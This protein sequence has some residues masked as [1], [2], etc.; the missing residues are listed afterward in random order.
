MAKKNKRNI[1]GILLLDKP[2]GIG[3]N[4][5]LQ[6][7]K[8]SLQAKKAGHTGSLDPLASGLLP[9][10]FGEATKISQYLLESNKTYQVTAKLGIKTDSADSDGEIVESQ[11]VPDFDEATLRQVLNSFLGDSEQIPPMYSAL[12]VDGQRLYKLARK[13]KV[14]ER[15]PRAIHISKIKL[16]DLTKDSIS[17]QVTVSKGTYIR[18]LVEDLAA[19]LGTVG[20]VTVL[21][22]IGV[23]PFMNPEMHELDAFLDLADEHK[24]AC[25]ISIESALGHWPQIQ[26][27]DAQS[28]DLQHGKPV[29][30]AET[31][32]LDPVLV[33]DSQAKALAI[34]EVGASGVLKSK[35]LFV[36]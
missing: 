19:E 22:R 25:L 16:I 11:T 31:R 17:F 10:C 35:R 8:H 7:V 20:H 14:I 2:S 24:Q 5:A 1:H 9:L 36:F 33:V 13:G 30:T 15:K 27:D 18:S 6:Q 32:T 4:K 12:K 29:Q 28:Q 34:G 3:S 21:R 26:L 23:S